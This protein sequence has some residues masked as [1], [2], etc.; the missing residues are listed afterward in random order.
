VTQVWGALLVLVTIIVVIIATS[1]ATLEVQR[2][3]GVK[4]R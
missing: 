1:G 3:R 2:R 4:A